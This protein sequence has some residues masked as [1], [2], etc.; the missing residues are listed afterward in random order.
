MF[1]VHLLLSSRR[2]PSGL[3]ER[4]V[5]LAAVGVDEMC[6]LGGSPSGSSA[7]CQSGSSSLG[8]GSLGS[9]WTRMRC[10][11]SAKVVCGTRPCSCA[12]RHAPHPSPGGGVTRTN[13]DTPDIGVPLV[14][15]RSGHPQKGR[16]ADC[17][18]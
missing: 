18:R 4:C 13:G 17:R 16:G 6:R 2:R 7:H 8:M 3:G 15:G 12:Y 1:N 10:M 9:S 14:D 5:D 11:A